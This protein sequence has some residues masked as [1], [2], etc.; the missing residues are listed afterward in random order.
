[1][2]TAFL[3]SG[4]GAQYIGMGKQFYDQ[5]DCV[6][7]IYDN[8]KLDF[9]VKQV[10]FE[11]PKE[12]LDDT[13]YAQSCIFVTSMAIVAV[14]KEAGIKADVCA[15][16]SLGEYSALC[17]SDSISVQDGAS[18]VRERGKLMAHA[19][20][21]NTS[22]MAA[23]LMLDKDAILE[24]CKEVSAIGVCEIANYN[25]PG[26]IVITGNKEA[27]EKACD[28]CLTKGARKAIPLQVSGAFHSSLL[29]EASIQLHDVLAQY[30]I[31]SPSIPVYH[32][33][34]GT[35]E[36]DPIIDLLSKQIAHS[37]YFEQTIMNML[38]DG[39][40]T[41]IEVGPGKAISG[42]VKKCAKGKDVFIAN[43]EDEDSLRKT[44]ALIGGNHG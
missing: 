38:E 18:I 12:Q 43:V 19:L 9:N 16:L 21:A 39:V 35:T 20:P 33:V 8:I 14:L 15:G 17:Y 6:K 44:I 32:N 25:C 40:T 7:A 31:L 26:Q 41:F 37:V 13:A 4:Q 2:K 42:F 34:S 28:I 3:F 1:M 36:T 24:A 10:C 11:G 30:S 23:I 29:N 27:V 5:Y 22:A